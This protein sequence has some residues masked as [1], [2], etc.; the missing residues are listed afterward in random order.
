MK[1][2]SIILGTSA[3]IL[4]IA[5]AF[6]TKGSSKVKFNEAFTAHG[7]SIGNRSDC[8][9]TGAKACKTALGAT[10]YTSNLGSAGNTLKTN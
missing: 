8:N 9:N 7:A 6:T 1:K 3:A 5:S 4:A 2:T 10:L